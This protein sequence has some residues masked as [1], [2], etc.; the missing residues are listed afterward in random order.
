MRMFSQ[1]LLLFWAPLID[2]PGLDEGPYP[3][4]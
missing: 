4:V 3:F 2:L 1:L